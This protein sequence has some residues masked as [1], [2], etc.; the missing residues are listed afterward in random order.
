[1]HPAE[2]FRRKVRVRIST[3][4]VKVLNTS[5]HSILTLNSLRLEH[6]K[7]NA[8]LALALILQTLLQNKPSKNRWE[9]YVPGVA[10]DI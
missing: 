9:E 8:A 7:F 1:M 4:A 5:S 2:K 6:E 3:V 10:D